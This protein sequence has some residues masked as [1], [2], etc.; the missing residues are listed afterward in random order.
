MKHSGILALWLILSLVSVVTSGC[1]YRVAATIQANAEATPVP[2]KLSWAA[3]PGPALSAS[4]PETL[5]GLQTVSVPL[6]TALSL[7]NWKWLSNPDQAAEADVLVRIWWM[8]DGPQY[9]TERADPF[10]RPGLS[11]GTGI[12]FGSSP[13]HRGPFGYARQAFYVPEPSIQAIYSRVL[14]VEALRADAL[15]KATLEAL[16]PAAKPSG[17]ASKPAPA[18][19]RDGDP[20]KGP[21]APPIALEG[22]ALS[23]PPYAAPLKATGADPDQEPPYAPPLLASASQG[24]PGRGRALARCGDE[25]RVKGQYLRNPPSACHRRG[26][27]RRQEHAGGRVRRQRHARDVREVNCCGKLE[28]GGEPF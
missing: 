28:G 22:E 2:T 1:G 7:Y 6:A 14:V 19:K 25:R 5:S 26:A 9:I 13:W 12:G 15:P 17:I 8:T 23:K 11:F 24:V 10:Y 4:A 16:L 21:Y 18:A 3:V 20:S 27:G